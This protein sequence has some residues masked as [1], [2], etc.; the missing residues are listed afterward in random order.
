[1]VTINVIKVT[2][3]AIMSNK[4]EIG[5]LNISKSYFPLIKVVLSYAIPFLKKSHNFIIIC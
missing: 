5:F 3:N 2:N 1:M 4:L